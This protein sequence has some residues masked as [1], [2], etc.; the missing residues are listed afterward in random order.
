MI[1][2]EL[3]KG[4]KTIIDDEDLEFV[5]KYNWAAKYDK[6]VYYARSNKSIKNPKHIYLHRLVMNVPDNLQVDHINRNT[7]DNR[8]SNLRICSSKENSRN[9]EKPI[10]NKSG[11]KGVSWHKEAKKWVARIGVDY[12]KLYLGLFDSK[13]D[14]AKAYDEAA[15]K[16]YGKFARKN[17]L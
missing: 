10:N 1:E 3:T 8:K 6:G 7:L 9:R 12:K 4:Y 11:Y 16:Y 15:E 14:A 5:L 2:I 13:E 17:F